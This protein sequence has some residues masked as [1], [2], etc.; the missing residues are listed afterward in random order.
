V[1][2]TP[3]DSR[4]VT[5]S[6]LFFKKPQFVQVPKGITIK[7]IVDLMYDRNSI[8]YNERNYQTILVEVDGVPISFDKW[9]RVPSVDQH[10]LV[11]FLLHGG[12]G[13]AQKDI[14]RAMMMLAVVVLSIYTGGAAAGAMG[15]TAGTGAAGA[16]YSAVAGGIAAVT[17]TAGMM[18]VN[19]IVP[20]PKQ[21][22]PTSSRNEESYGITGMS[23][24]A[25]PW[26]P[27]PVILGTHKIYPL[28]GS[29][30]YT[31][32]VGNDEYLRSLFVYGYGPVTITEIKIGESDI[33]LYEDVEIETREGRSTDA[34][35]TLIPQ[36]V[37]QESIQ[38]RLKS[39]DDAITRKVKGT[40]TDGAD[41]IGI[42]IIFPQ[43]LY[44][45]VEDSRAKMDAI[46]EVWYQ[47]EGAGS[48]THVDG[49]FP[50]SCNDEEET[51]HTFYWNDRTTKPLRLGITWTVDSTKTYYVKVQKTWH[52]AKY[53]DKPNYAQ[54]CQWEYTKTILHE[55]PVSFSQP[56]AMTGLK[57]KATEQLNGII[58]DLNATVSSYATIWDGS[59]WTGEAVTNNP[60]ALFRMVLMHPANVKA[61]EATQIDDTGL[62]E[63]YEFCTINTY[64]FNQIRDSK[65]SVWECLADI[66][67][68][69]RASPSIIDGVWGVVVDS[70]DKETVQHITPRNSWGFS[71]SKKLYDPPHG[72]RVKFKNELNNYEDDERIVL[73]D[74]YQINGYDAFGIFVGTA[75]V[76]PATIFESVEFPGITHP[77]LVHKF[78]RYYMAAAR[79]RPEV[80]TL[81]MDF[82]H[83]VCKRGDKVLVAHDVPMWG[84]KW[85]RIKSLITESITTETGGG[86]FEDGSSGISW[87]DTE[88]ATW[89][90]G[91]ATNKVMGVVLDEKFDIT[92]SSQYV[93]RVRRSDNNNSQLINLTSMA[94]GTYNTALF[95]TTL[96][97]DDAL[98]P[99]VGDLV[100]IGELS[101]ETNECLVKS[102]HAENDLNAK[103]ELV[104]FADEIYDAD[105]GEIPEFNPNITRV[106]EISMI[107]P[108]VP[109]IYS[110]QSGT[111]CMEIGVGGRLAPRIFVTCGVGLTDT[112]IQKFEVRY[113]L[114]GDSRWSF[115][116]C[117]VQD[118][119]AICTYVEEGETYEIVARSISIYGVYSAWT[120]I[121]KHTVVGQ[122]ELPDNVTRFTCNII[123]SEAYLSW[124]PIND[125]DLSHYRIRWSP[126]TSGALWP[127]AIDIVAKVAKPSSSITVPAMLGSYL[128]KAVDY[129]GNESANATIALSS[130]IRI[131]GFTNAVTISQPAWSGTG[132]DTEY[133]AGIDGIILSYTT[134]GDNIIENG[135]DFTG[136]PIDD[137]TVFDSTIASV[138][139]GYSGNCL[140]VTKVSGTTQGASQLISPLTFEKSY[141]LSARVKSGTSGDEAFGIYLQ[142]DGV[143]NRETI[144]G[145]TSNDWVKY[146]LAFR[147]NETIN[148]ITLIKGTSTA[149]T[150]LFDSIELYENLVSNG[151]DWTGGDPN[152]AALYNFE[153]GYLLT[154]SKSTNDLYASA[155]TPTL[156]T[157]DYMEGT[158]C[159]DFELDSTQYFYRNDADLAS[160]FPFKSGTTNNRISICAWFK[161][162][163]FA[164]GSNINSIVSKYNTG[165]NRRS[166]SVRVFEYSSGVNR[167]ELII[168]HT[169]GT[170]YERLQHGSNL[171]LD[172]WYHITAT[173]DNTNMSYSLR[174]KDE[175]GN[176]LG[177]DVA[178]IALHTISFTTE[179]FRIGI[180]YNGT[181]FY[182]GSRFDGLIDEVAIFSDIISSSEATNIALGTYE[183]GGEVTGWATTDCTLS[184]IAGGVVG[185]CLELTSTGGN[186][187]YAS[188][189][190]T[191]EIGTAYRLSGYTKSGSAGND[192]FVLL[193]YDNDN[194]SHMVD[195]TGVSSTTWVKSTGDFIATGEDCSVGLYKNTT[196]A[197][198]PGT[199]LF[200][201]ITLEE[202]ELV[203]EGYYLLSNVADLE[204]VYTARISASL[205][206]SAV[207]MFTDL[208]DMGNLY[209][210]TNLYDVSTGE[211]G[212]ELEIRTTSDDPDGTPTWS[213]WTPVIIGDFTARAFQFRLHLWSNDTA[214]TPIL[215]S[216]D[217][218]VDLADRT[219][220]FDQIIS[221]G[222]ETV[223]YQYPFYAIPSISLSIMNG[224]S[225]DTYAITSPTRSSFFINFGTGLTRTIS[226]IAKGYGL[227]EI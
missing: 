63:W 209:A 168:G 64:A 70:S 175:T 18:L 192:D 160:D 137:W 202:V 68:A 191:L 164:T 1:I 103:L 193:A 15:F 106:P 154:D 147:A 85:G 110:I 123:G 30:P 169:D 185:N 105:V 90:K 136:D 36:T 174:L 32:L 211:C 83:L 67:A 14:G 86:V 220:G 227:E 35:I 133:D 89:D 95:E 135:E 66:A 23:N 177:S 187:Q 12:S 167:A 92:S 19:A 48:W 142:E 208:Y 65:S 178:A 88:D 111:D 158:A 151:D 184:S 161:P 6:P 180:Q 134:T 223:T 38:I 16:A 171:T 129:K 162:E 96:D 57:I 13:N 217:A 45:M 108:A 17:A 139:G 5:M 173:F 42:N 201:E 40:D 50:T 132:S 195:I 221:S 120:D 225:T 77:N 150:M 78:A 204:G 62:G 99:L 157:T 109:I 182:S 170:G 189:P 190:V 196:H 124:Y 80:Y 205:S 152:C 79:L 130:I 156:C 44:Q 215:V 27:I 97:P 55:Q 148:K 58:D 121:I 186:F 47:E 69:G 71:S 107:V 87:E 91:A 73:D 176:T 3:S 56:L 119:T 213:D 59:S 183:A 117:N 140:K 218:Y 179:P 141:I 7:E 22:E 116:E 219:C 144:D 222:G 8:P 34:D 145:V 46:V 94:I 181:S 54:Y 39:G 25:N 102:I 155:S 101:Q 194:S 163:S 200:D 52:E 224:A 210:L 75:T 11:S 37:I 84:T 216:V 112:R 41:E 53:E 4:K 214:V 115:T 128:I 198:S 98:V 172:T 104:D 165:S 100:I 207:N 76:L 131:P 122:S 166:F 28:Y 127:D 203:K 29:F 51:H 138:S 114:L 153:S 81:S 206:T 74:D 33:S 199:M 212:I 146:T 26:G 197:A 20:L 21:H 60:A 93:M 188:F 143:A 49:I 2:I 72:F 226:G 10:V 9:E 126:L 24:S 159:A 118:P 61:R 31:E 125:L 82:E 113:R 149:G 43:G